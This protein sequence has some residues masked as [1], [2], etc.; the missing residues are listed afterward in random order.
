MEIYTSPTTFTLGSKRVHVAHGDNLNIVR[1][2]VSLRLMNSFFRSRI[3]RTLFTWLIHPNI[4]MWFGRSWSNAS[5]KKHS[6]EHPDLQLRGVGFLRE[7]G[8]RHFAEHGDDIYIFGH[9]HYPAIYDMER[10]Q[11]V[12]MND[13]SSNP[14]YAQISECGDVELLRVKE[15]L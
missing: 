9:I 10:P 1:S 13:W 7:Y 3:A 14:H 8:H 5:R 4:A 11:M 6:T 12:F 2:N 15:L